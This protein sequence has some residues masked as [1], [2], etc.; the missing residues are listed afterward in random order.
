MSVPAHPLLYGASPP[1]RD[2]LP[3][4]AA[5]G[6]RP[7]RAAAAS[8]ASAGNGKRHRRSGKTV[9]ARRRG[10]S[11][12]AQ[13]ASVRLSMTCAKAP[14]RPLANGRSARPPVSERERKPYGTAA[15]PSSLTNF[16]SVEPSTRVPRTLVK[17]GRCAG[18]AVLTSRL[19]VTGGAAVGPLAVEMAAVLTAS[20]PS[21]VRASPAQAGIGDVLEK[22]DGLRDAVESVVVSRVLVEHRG[23]GDLR[24]VERV[25]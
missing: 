19:A 23:G 4:S 3:P 7:W 5:R 22:R 2:Q 15:M 17:I 21:V 20:V 14:R 25:L 13:A 9:R 12:R 1:R 18:A 8:P 16:E 10:A 11:E 24:G 6:D